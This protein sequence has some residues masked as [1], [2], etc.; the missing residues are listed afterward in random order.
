MT[1]KSKLWEILDKKGYLLDQDIAN[2][3]GKEEEINWVTALE[4]KRQWLR[5]K[6]DRE[7]FKDKKILSISKYKGCKAETSEGWYKIGRDYFEELKPT[8]KRDNSRP[9]L[10]IETYINK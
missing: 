4:Y 7:F 10:S 1:I 9:D 6:Q 2:I 8:F 5:L 3:Y